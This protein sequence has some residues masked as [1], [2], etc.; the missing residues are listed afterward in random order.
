MGTHPFGLSAVPGCANRRIRGGHWYRTS[1]GIISSTQP[2][3]DMC[4]WTP[5]WPAY[6]GTIDA[7]AFEVTQQAT[8]TGND[9]LT[10]GIYNDDGQGRPTGSAL[11]QTS[12]QSLEVAPAVKTVTSLSW[13]GIV[14]KLYWLA[15][16]RFTNSAVSSPVPLLRCAANDDFKDRMVSDSNATPAAGFMGA[17]PS[18]NYQQAMVATTLPTVATL[19][20]GTQTASPLL[21]V[22][23]T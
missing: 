8:N 4:I 5:F 3:D 21:L 10:I 6:R 2:L 18:C 13:T 7:V 14:P 17:A 19:L 11:F 15:A 1:S 20:M 12:S 22:K 9:T 23:F 16:G